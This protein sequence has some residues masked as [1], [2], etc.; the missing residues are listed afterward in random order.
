[1]I[2]QNH[3]RP[4]LFFL[5]GMKSVLLSFYTLSCSMSWYYPAGS[6]SIA[7]RLTKRHEA[8]WSRLCQ[9]WQ[10]SMM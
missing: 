3:S 1:M 5:Q 8:I 2:F 7:L 10:S 9:S 6:L 4:A